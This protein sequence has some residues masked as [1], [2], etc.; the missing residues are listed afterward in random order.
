MIWNPW[1][2]IRDLEQMNAILADRLE[3]ETEEA[4]RRIGNVIAAHYRRIE[5]ENRYRDEMLRV[6]QHRMADVSSYMPF[7]TVTRTT[8]GDK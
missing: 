1:K 4:D 7:A 8:D 6:T 3:Y 5:H 2:R